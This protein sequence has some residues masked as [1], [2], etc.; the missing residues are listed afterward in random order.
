MTKENN[1]T[2][3]NLPYKKEIEERGRTIPKPS[4]KPTNKPISNPNKKQ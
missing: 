1:K 4:F 3:T 2:Q